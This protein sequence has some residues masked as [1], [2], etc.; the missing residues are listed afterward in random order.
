[1]TSYITVEDGSRVP[2]SEGDDVTDLLGII[3]YEPPIPVHMAGE[4]FNA[5]GMTLK[6][7]I[8]N[9][10]RYC[11]PYQEGNEFDLVVCVDH[12]DSPIL[13]S[14]VELIEVVDIFE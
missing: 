13:P 14:G 7:D 9:F 12:N 10:R 3:K 5:F 6:Y 2:V 1:M 8:E 4:V 11:T